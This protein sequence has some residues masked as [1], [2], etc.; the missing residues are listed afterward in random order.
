MAASFP[1]HALDF[2]EY[3]PDAVRLVTDFLEAIIKYPEVHENHF[4]VRPI[5]SFRPATRIGTEYRLAEKRGLS[6]IENPRRL[7]S[8][9]TGPLFTHGFIEP[10]SS[11]GTARN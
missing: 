8:D 1:K 6:A 5:W 3:D 4:T 7:K 2:L 10:D 11:A 9:I